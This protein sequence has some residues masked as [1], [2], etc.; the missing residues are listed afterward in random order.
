M[1]LII[2]AQGAGAG[3]GGNRL[4]AR[5]HALEQWCEEVPGMRRYESRA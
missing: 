5:A 3:R 4:H 1:Q 2:D